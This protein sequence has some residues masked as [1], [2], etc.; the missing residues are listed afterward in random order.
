M[1]LV[2]NVK[3]ADFQKSSDYRY[4]PEHIEPN[5][6]QKM[7]KLPFFQSAPIIGTNLYKFSENT[8]F[9]TKYR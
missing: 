7:L 4:K 8:Q 3:I 5:L 1:A 6:E 2:K 9:G